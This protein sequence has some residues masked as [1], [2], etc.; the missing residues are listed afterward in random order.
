MDDGAILAG[1]DSEPEAFAVFYRRHV[2]ALLAYVERCTQ[3][4]DMAAEVCAEAFATALVC[5]HRFDREGGPAADWLYGIADR[6][7]AHAE[8]SGRVEGRAQRRLGMAW[9]GPGTDFV[10]ALEEELVAAAQFRAGRRAHRPRLA[11]P[12]TPV[13]IGVAALAVAV[14][15][16]ALSAGDDRPAVP[17]RAAT[18]PP[19]PAGAAFPL[20]P[21][22][23]LVSCAEPATE[24]LA[25][26]TAVDGIAL[27]RRPQREADAIPFPPTR[28]PI[29]S[30]DPGATRSPAHGQRWSTVHVVPSSRVAANGDCGVRGG[31]GACLVADAREFSCFTREELSG[32]R[33]L[34]KG[35][36]G[37]VVGIVPDGVDH[38]TILGEGPPVGAD[39][40]ENV[41]EAYVDDL[42]G[43]GIELKFHRL[44]GDGCHRDVAP[45]LLTR[46]P[47]LRATTQ[48]GAL[49]RAALDAL[50]IYPLDTVVEDAARFWGRDRGV[51]FWVVP[52]VPLG[53]ERC[54]PATSAC[55]VAVTA[56]GRADAECVL[57][58]ERGV[59][60]WRLVPLLAGHAAIYGVVPDAVTG[61]R[62]TIDGRTAK[63]D[64]RDNVLAGV[65]PFPYRDTAK[66]RVELIRS[67]VAGS[68]P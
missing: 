38:V 33:A 35:P 53:P 3:D 18:A 65:L 60:A 37:T 46:L 45:A 25:K 30:F 26:R 16:V 4:R 5:A 29:G 14:A 39:V 62:V 27:L 11:L 40:S 12:R 59:D 51:E 28:L 17:R 36:Q 50:R 63:V 31:P 55:I 22:R 57:A 61:A 67:P 49:P 54:A 6:L 43:S 10:D 13:L 2:E 42:A 44:D 19:P 7:L 47:T 21:M 68:E 9:L 58:E 66:T 64:A 23:P 1:L 24:S 20:V 56:D 48:P 52:V 32:G 34:A 8:R 41:Y 15:L